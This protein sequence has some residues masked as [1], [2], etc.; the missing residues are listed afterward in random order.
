MTNKSAESE[1]L[2]LKKQIENILSQFKQIRSE[3]AG[4]LSSGNIPDAALQLHDVLQYTEQATSTIIEAVSG[5]NTVVSETDLSQETKDKI[6]ALVNSV[7]EACNFQDISGQR[8]KKVLDH[9]EEIESQIA[10][11]SEGEKGNVVKK[12]KDK[13]PLLNGPQ[14]SGDAPSQADIDNLFNS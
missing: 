10:A 4:I 11:L 6:G 2:E 13:D 5:I 3:A 9:I 12:K 8:I 7:Y 14:L 1:L